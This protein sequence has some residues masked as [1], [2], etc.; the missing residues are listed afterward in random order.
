MEKSQS[1]SSITEKLGISCD[2]CMAD[3][4]GRKKLPLLLLLLPHTEGESDE[5]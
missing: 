2:G 1:S 3:K 4:K 5:D